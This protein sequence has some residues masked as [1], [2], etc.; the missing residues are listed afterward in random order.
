MHK[1]LRFSKGV[2]YRP[3]LHLQAIGYFFYVR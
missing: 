2:I 1:P 3:V